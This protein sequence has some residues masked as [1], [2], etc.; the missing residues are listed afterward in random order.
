MR[1]GSALEV[2]TFPMCAT[3]FLVFSAEANK[4][5]C[6]SSV[7]EPFVYMH[8]LSQ[9]KYNSKGHE[10]KTDAQEKQR[11][12]IFMIYVTWFI[13][14]AWKYSGNCLHTL[15]QHSSMT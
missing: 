15:R 14:M 6:C 10:K 2:S 5:D 11:V 4:D 3:Y 8:Y 9:K 13:I 12:A 1:V 7:F